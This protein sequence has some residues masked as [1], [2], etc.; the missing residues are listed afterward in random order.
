MNGHKAK[1][2]RRTIYGDYSTKDRESKR[3]I[4]L[5]RLYQRAKKNP[6]EALNW[7]RDYVDQHVGS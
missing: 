3:G 6:T 2:L 7:G 5:R 1:L 4:F